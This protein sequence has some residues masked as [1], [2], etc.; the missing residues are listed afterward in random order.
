MPSNASSGV[1]TRR[2]LIVKDRKV[3]GVDQPR[4]VLSTLTVA[5]YLLPANGNNP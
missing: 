5:G 4:A 3:R 2:L 1:R